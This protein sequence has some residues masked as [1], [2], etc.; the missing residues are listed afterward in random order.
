MPRD[1]RP[2]VYS[3]EH[4]GEK[5]CP[6]CGQIPCICKKSTQNLPPNQQTAF[7]RRET[8]RRGGKT[9]T[10][11]YNLVLASDSLKSL[12]TSLKKAC[13]TGGT[14]KEGTIEIQ[15]DYRDKIAAELKKLGYKVKFTGG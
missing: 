6:R 5:P 14:A 15:G 7:I 9:V 4:N 8:K 12:A 2:V 13:G 3:T 11:V 1:E 10:V